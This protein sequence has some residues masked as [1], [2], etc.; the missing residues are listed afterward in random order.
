MVL[1]T[2]RNPRDCAGESGEL[3]CSLQL[4]HTRNKKQLVSISLK[5]LPLQT[6]LHFEYIDILLYLL[7]AD[8]GVGM[9]PH[10]PQI[11]PRLQF[12]G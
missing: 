1:S 3:W 6:N 8:D 7:Q 11:S 10:Q 2:A 12:T 4:R 9:T 5:D